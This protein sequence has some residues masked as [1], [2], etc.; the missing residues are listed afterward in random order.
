M[1]DPDQLKLLAV[2]GVAAVFKVLLSRW[3]G[4]VSA[5]ISIAAAV[6]V[7]WIMTDP[8][9]HFFQMP[10]EIYDHQVAAIWA[11]LGVNVLRW[12]VR[13]SPESLF[14]LWRSRK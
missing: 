7:A 8:T 9:L 12:L 10:S 5:L 14:K 2:A 4:I 11:L 3:E 13:Q 1:L 6:F